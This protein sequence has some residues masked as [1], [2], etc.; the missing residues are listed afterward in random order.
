MRMNAVEHPKSVDINATTLVIGPQIQKSSAFPCLHPRL[1]RALVHNSDLFVRGTHDA[2][3]RIDW[4]H[5]RRLIRGEY[6]FLGST[7]HSSQT[8]RAELV[9]YPVAKGVSGF[10]IRYGFLSL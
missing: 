10:A 9:L 4:R 3:I 1:V 6:N 5:R 7:S 8:A 2:A